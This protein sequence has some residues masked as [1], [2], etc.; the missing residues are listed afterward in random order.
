[1]KPRQPTQTDLTPDPQPKTVTVNG[2]GLMHW[3]ER[4]KAGEVHIYRMT[5]KSMAVKDNGIYEIHLM[6]LAGRRL[7]GWNEK[8]AAEPERLTPLTSRQQPTAVHRALEHCHA[9][10][11]IKL[12]NQKK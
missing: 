8:P 7:H 3:G 2:A 1:M 11:L 5:C 4:A 12:A 9:E 10:T 6:W